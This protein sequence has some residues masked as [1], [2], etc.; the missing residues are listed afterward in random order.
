MKKCKR[1]SIEVGSKFRWYD[2]DLW[3]IVNI[4][5]DKED[6]MIVIKSWA[7]YKNRWCYQVVFK[8]ELEWFFSRHLYDEVNSK[9]E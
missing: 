4:F 8:E 9:E 3:H 5:Q 6:T 1:P 7:K 2:R